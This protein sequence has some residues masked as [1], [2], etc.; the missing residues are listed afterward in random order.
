MLKH[1]LKSD[2]VGEKQLRR[3]ISTSF[4]LKKLKSNSMHAWATLK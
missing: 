3:S 1:N 4:A 2:S